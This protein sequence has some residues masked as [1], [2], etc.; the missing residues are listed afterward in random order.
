M[1]ILERANHR[2]LVNHLSPRCIHDDTPPL[3]RP[4]LPLAHEMHRVFS[5]RYMYTQ[6]IRLATQRLQTVHVLAPRRCVYYAVAVVIHDAHGK[7]MYEVGETEADP[8]ESNNTEGA[9]G[10][11]VRVPR[12]DGCFPRACVKG[13]FGSGKVAKGGEDEVEGCSGG[14]VVDGARGI[15]HVDACV[16]VRF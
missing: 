16:K 7:G 5:E 13:T 8:A 4:N 6:H 10:E 15:R 12:G 2:F 1:T 14:C 11:I 9:V 3:H